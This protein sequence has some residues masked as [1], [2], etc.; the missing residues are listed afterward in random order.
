MTDLVEI[1]SQWNAI[2]DALE[3]QNRIAWLAYFDARLVEIR[4]E[5]LV[6]SFADSQKLAGAHDY[7]TVRKSTHRA[8]LE[9][10]ILAVT[11]CSLK[12]IEE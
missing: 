7:K 5:S 2:L 4:G 8:A 10:A 12:V 11:G 9:E 3:A 6:L 1:K